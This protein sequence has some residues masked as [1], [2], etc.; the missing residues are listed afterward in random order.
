MTRPTWAV[1]WEGNVAEVAGGAAAVNPGRTP[2]CG[3]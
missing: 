2:G 1:W 3:Y